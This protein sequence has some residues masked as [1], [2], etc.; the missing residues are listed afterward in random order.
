MSKIR[1]LLCK[2][3]FHSYQHKRIER[4]YPYKHLK[5]KYAGFI[6]ECGTKSITHYDKCCYCG[7][8]KNKEHIKL[9]DKVVNFGIYSKQK[10]LAF[11]P[12]PGGLG[13]LKEEAER[14]GE[15]RQIALNRKS[16]ENN[17]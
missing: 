6:Y 14:R 13:F 7:K 1:K 9:S 16:S 8:E 17:F 12:L 11:S 15:N 2:L 5:K 4:F 10:Y 3:G